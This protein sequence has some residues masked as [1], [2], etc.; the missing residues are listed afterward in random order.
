MLFNHRASA[1]A[2][3]TWS[4][5]WLLFYRHHGGDHRCHQFLVS[6]L[7]GETI[8]CAD[9]QISSGTNDAP[10]RDHTLALRRGEKID[11]VFDREYIGPGRREAHRGVGAGRIDDARDH[12]RVQVAVLLCQVCA[13]R[14]LYLDHAGSDA[15]QH[16]SD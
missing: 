12:A 8:A 1:T 16:S 7:E 15:C 5:Y 3:L 10:A 14:Q 2:H 13:K 11:L 9:G 4:A 6:M